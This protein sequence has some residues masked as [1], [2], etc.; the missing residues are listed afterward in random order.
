MALLK[1]NPTRMELTK[2][3]KRLL[4]ARRGH[5]L[6]KDKRDE[7][8]KQFLELVKKNRLLRTEVEKQLTKIHGSFS[9]AA[10]VMSSQIVEESL[11]YPKQ[12]IELSA[13]NKNVMSVNVP[14]FEYKMKNQESDIYS[15]GFAFTSGELD[16][17]VGGL[18]EILPKLV[19]L[20]E[21]EKSVMLLA[22][23]IEKTRRR[24]NALEHVLIPQLFDTIKYIVMKLDENERGNLTRLMKVKDMMVEQAFKNNQNQ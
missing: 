13:L 18:S 3:K 14:V 5:K 15:Y 11:I 7:M 22:G 9:I 24:V 12:G 6:L 10:A 17:A 20:A 2:L 4:T 1:V 23:E 16:I 19:E 8:V 21:T